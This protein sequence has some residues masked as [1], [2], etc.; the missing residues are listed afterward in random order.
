MINNQTEAFH[1][2]YGNNERQWALLLS[3]L[4]AEHGIEAS[5]SD[6][7]KY[8][9][10]ELSF[11]NRNKVIFI[12]ESSIAKDHTKGLPMKFNNFGIKYGWLGNS[13]ILT[14]ENTNMDR[15]NFKEF[16][17]FVVEVSHKINNELCLTHPIPLLAIE[18]VTKKVSC[19]NDNADSLMLTTDVTEESSVLPK[20]ELTFKDKMKNNSFFKKMSENSQKFAGIVTNITDKIGATANKVMPDK[21]ETVDIKWHIVIRLFFFE[22]LEKFV[23]SI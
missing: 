8:N 18:S 10:Q 7:S 3:N 19:D 1:I 6:E 13:A 16:V 20:K 2:V 5:Y 22:G 21:K 4:M 12:G 15:I 9:A 23:S 17:D 14:I 11:S